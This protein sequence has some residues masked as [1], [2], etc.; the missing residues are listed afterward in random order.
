M[1]DKVF[2][3][4]VNKEDTATV[5]TQPQTTVND[6]DSSLIV[7]LTSRTMQ[8]CSMMATTREEKAKLYNATNNPD[9]RLADMINMRIE[10]KDVYVEAV[11]CINKETGAMN[12]CP[13]IVLIDKDGVGYQC[14]SIGVFSAIKKMFGIYGEPQEWE[15]P[16]PI[17]VKQITKGEKQLL[18]LNVVIE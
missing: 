9:F 2:D 7:D 18:T 12:T 4:S 1:E 3:L 16:I 17:M 5:S 10:L 8:Y 6:D 15:E 11:Q 13:R 14:V